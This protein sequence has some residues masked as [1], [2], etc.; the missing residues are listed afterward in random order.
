MN[1]AWLIGFLLL[2]TGGAYAAE[3]AAMVAVP[4]LLEPKDVND[5]ITAD[6]LTTIKL[7]AKKVGGDILTDSNSIIG[8]APRRPLRANVPLRAIDLRKQYL[9]LKNNKV[10]M[11]YQ[12]GPLQLTAVGKALEN[13]A[14]D[15]MVRILNV[16][17]NQTVE[18]RVSAMGTV[19]MD[20]SPLPAIQKNTIQ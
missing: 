15:D 13:G 17:S 12:S 11:L 8:Q 6:D 1:R 4:V 7:E 3:E 5:V 2:L 20:N 9:V 18:G 19:R 14:L 16:G 10:T